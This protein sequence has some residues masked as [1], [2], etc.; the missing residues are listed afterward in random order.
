M[1]RPA[2]TTAAGL[3]HQGRTGSF[4]CHLIFQALGDTKGVRSPHISRLRERSAGR[5]FDV[6]MAWASGRN[7]SSVFECEAP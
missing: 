7:A 4:G 6:P 5:C 2:R 1:H 3:L